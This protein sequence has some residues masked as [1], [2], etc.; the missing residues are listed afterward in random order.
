VEKTEKIV[1]ES[2]M[3]FVFKKRL[4]THHDL[5]RI[6][7]VVSIQKPRFYTAISQN[8]PQKPPQ[9]KLA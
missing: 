8:R 9:K 6:Y 4:S 7:H 5:P 3:F 1:K 2:G